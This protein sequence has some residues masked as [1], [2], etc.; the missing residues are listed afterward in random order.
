MLPELQHTIKMAL[1]HTIK[2]VFELDIL[3]ADINV[4]FPPKVEMGDLAFPIA[5]ELGSYPTIVRRRKRA[6]L[7]QK[8]R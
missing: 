3:P 6:L 2:R 4:E 8:T 1:S 5:F 7:L